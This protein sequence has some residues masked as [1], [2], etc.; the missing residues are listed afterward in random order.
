MNKVTKTQLEFTPLNGKKV[1]AR[2]DEPCV[3][4][5]GGVLLLREVDGQIGLSRA[6]IKDGVPIA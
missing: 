2:F 6:F 3:S 1:T 5:D 4:S